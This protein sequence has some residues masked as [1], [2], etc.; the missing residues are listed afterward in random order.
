[1]TGTL[2][3][4]RILI[5]EDEYFIA[6]ELKRTL[7]NEGAVVV[8]PVSDLE[9]GLMLAEEPLD[10][11]VLDVNLEET[12]S[13]PIADRLSSRG[14]PYMFLTGYDGWSLPAQHR[15]TARLAKPFM[16]KSVVAMVEKLV[17]PEA[18]IA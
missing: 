4:K 17:S 2:A 14:I 10:A 5:V 15:E 8:G 7:K 11:A 16:S 1:M 18:E 3:D 9:G 13:Y 6:S 12:L